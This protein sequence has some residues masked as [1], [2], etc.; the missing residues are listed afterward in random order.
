MCMYMYVFKH[1]SASRHAFGHAFGCAE[2]RGPSHGA[3]S[4]RSNPF[5][6]RPKRFTARHR[7]APHGREGMA[8]SHNGI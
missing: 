6:N 8:V 5:P 1:R 4:S 3:M 7:A 2:T